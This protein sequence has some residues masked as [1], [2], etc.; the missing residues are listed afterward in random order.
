MKLKTKFVAIMIASIAVGML[1]SFGVILS[2]TSSQL[3]QYAVRML[4]GIANGLDI[5]ALRS[6][7]DSLDQ[8]SE[9]FARLNKY[10]SAAR[11]KT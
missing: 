4:Y 2:L 9:E 11:K 10:L 6:V 7:I 3:G 8:N 5:E 1:I